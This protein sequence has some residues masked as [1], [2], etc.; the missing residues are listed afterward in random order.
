MY[1]EIVVPTTATNVNRNACSNLNSGRTTP[2][3][4]ALQSGRERNAETM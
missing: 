1:G 4:T 2:T 3:A